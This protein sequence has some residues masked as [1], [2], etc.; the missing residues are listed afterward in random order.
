M[1][2]IAGCVGAKHMAAFYAFC[3]QRHTLPKAAEIFAAP[4][5]TPLPNTPAEIY[6]VVSSLIPAAT[7]ATMEH[8]LKYIQRTNSAEFVTFYLNGLAQRDKAEK[9]AQPFTSH[10][11]YN[12]MIMSLNA[13][14]TE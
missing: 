2:A 7:Y 8:G 5:V 13:N 1:E 12:T 6:S 14:V 3:A 9:N 11:A 10:P 4:L